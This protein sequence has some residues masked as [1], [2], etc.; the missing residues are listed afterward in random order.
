MKTKWI[1]LLLSLILSFSY[2]FAQDYRNLTAE[3]LKKMMDKKT[4]MVIVDSRTD[5]EYREGRLPKA[6]NIPDTK[7]N[8]ISSFLPKDKTVPVVFYCRGYA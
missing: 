8:M 3:D 6:I 4:K 7:L 1:F 2:S 5:Q